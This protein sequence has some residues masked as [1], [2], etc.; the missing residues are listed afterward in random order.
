MTSLRQIEQKSVELA[1]RLN[2]YTITSKKKG[3]IVNE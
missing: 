1:A 3:I 2:S